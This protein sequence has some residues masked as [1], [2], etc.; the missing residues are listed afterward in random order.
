M[1]TKEYVD[2]SQKEYKWE[3][4][5]LSGFEVHLALKEMGYSLMDMSVEDAELLLDTL[6]SNLQI[7]WTTPIKDCLNFYAKDILIKYDKDKN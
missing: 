3:I 5:S 7:V 4:F 1:T 6:H 2:L